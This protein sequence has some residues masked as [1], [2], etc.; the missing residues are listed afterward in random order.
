MKKALKTVNVLLSGIGVMMIAVALSPVN[1]VSAAT[2][3]TLRDS[4]TKESGKE[5]MAEYYA[6]YDGDGIEEMFAVVGNDDMGGGQYIWFAS[7]NMTKCVY[8]DGDSLYFDTQNE[9]ICTV[10]DSQKLF[11]MEHGGY[12]SG[13]NSLCYYLKKGEPVRLNVSE[14]LTHVS[15]A[16]FNIYPSA[17][18]YYVDE[19]G[20]ATGHTWKPYYLKWKGYIFDEYT[21]GQITL[22]QFKKYTGGKKYIKK[23]K[24]EGYQIDSI[25]LRSNGIININVHYLDE[26]GGCCYD[27]VNFKLKNKKIKLLKGWNPDASGVVASSTY[28]GCYV[29]AWYTWD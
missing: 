12:G 25:I 22:K 3:E 13:S 14:G 5:I 10:S 11:I 17:F 21:G 7:D 29:P 4:I 9:R 16:D 27:N 28:G 15:G 8:D 19:F 20:M 1:N 26:Y 2:A 23:I 6:D 24:K 18:D